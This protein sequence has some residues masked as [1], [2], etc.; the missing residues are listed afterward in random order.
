MPQDEVECERRTRHDEV[1]LV[2]S[3]FLAQQRQKRVVEFFAA[4]S[5]A[6]ERFRI[7]VD[8]TRPARVQRL[9]HCLIQLDRA[10][11]PRIVALKDKNAPRWFR[12]LDLLGENAH[13]KRN[14]ERQ[15]SFTNGRQAAA[16]SVALPT[17]LV[18]MD[19]SWNQGIS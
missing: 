10:R 4:K 2:A 11:Q 7:N 12:G 6:V 8:Q 3:V 1:R 16:S 19:R 13:A 5:S 18:P 14:C 9:P 15:D 17:S